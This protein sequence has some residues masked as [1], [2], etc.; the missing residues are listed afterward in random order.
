MG[1]PGVVVVG[2]GF[3]CRVHVP[4]ARAAG[5]DV[6]GLVGRNRERTEERAT[7]CEIGGAFVSLEEALRQP[8]AD[9]VIVSTPPS[10]HAELTEEVLAAGR[11]VLLEKPFTNTTDEAR[12]L[13]DL[14]GKAGVVAL[15]GH[16]F[17]F[18]PE[19]VTMRQA[20]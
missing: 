10:S 4:A 8:G 11:H 7:Q 14:A 6:V 16:E 15:L 3:G 17:R 19:R 18:A 20:L 13:V 2:T 9:V 12:R 1:G 5:F